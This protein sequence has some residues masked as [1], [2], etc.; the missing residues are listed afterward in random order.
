MATEHTHSETQDSKSLAELTFRKKKKVLPW[1][2]SSA[3][4]VGG[5][6][7]ESFVCWGERKKYMDLVLRDLC[8]LQQFH[9]W[10]GEKT[11]EN[12]NAW[13]KCIVRPAYCSFNMLQT[14]Y[15][16]W[17]RFGH[18]LLSTSWFYHQYYPL[19][20]LH[21]PSPHLRP[22]PVASAAILT[23]LQTPPPPVS[24]TLPAPSS[25][26]PSHGRVQARPFCI[27]SGVAGRRE[28]LM[29]KLVFPCVCVCE[30]LRANLFRESRDRETMVV[31]VGG[32][33]QSTGAKTIYGTG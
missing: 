3:A 10:D 14:Y 22:K 18:H 26:F 21:G 25:T 5:I 1:L 16:R 31:G 33:S 8:H 9:Q 30:R 27:F 20:W 4:A 28:T 23:Y 17:P 29:G 6:K 15:M 32:W 2:L 7:N 24:V 11:F 12:I 13:M 19:N